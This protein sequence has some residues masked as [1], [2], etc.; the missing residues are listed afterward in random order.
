VQA[1][2][3]HP[4]IG[5]Y[6][7][8]E[9]RGR[10]RDQ[11]KLGPNQ[12]SGISAYARLVKPDPLS[13]IVVGLDANI[14]LVV[15]VGGGT[16]MGCNTA[17]SFFALG[18]LNVMTAGGGGAESLVVA[19]AAADGVEKLTVFGS[20][21]QTVA[22]PLK[23]NLFAARVALVQF[24]IRLVGYNKRG[25]IVAVRTVQSRLFGDVLPASAWT[26]SG[27]R[28]RVLGPN[29]ATAN[30]QI[31]RGTKTIRCWH[32]HFSTGQTRRG[33]NAK[34]PT[35]PWV[36]TDLV[37]QA[38]NDLF[39]VGDV[40]DPVELV[41]LRFDDGTTLKTQPKAGVFVF[42]IPRAYLH[43]QRQLA[44]VRGYDAHGFVVQ[45]APVLFK[46]RGP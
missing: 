37:Q 15:A 41:K 6:T 36:Y 5:W 16:G 45:R 46:V 1:R 29:G 38:G 23:D 31:T 11:L 35:G 42:A 39:V 25:R 30:L 21:G 24:P 12:L 13:D 22:I 44:F 14:C 27:P 2:I 33:C 19:G 10:S 43:T 26:P 3:A 8:G 17:S 4:T 20:D 7:R 32:I 18:P 40:R 34:Y 9:R 28:F